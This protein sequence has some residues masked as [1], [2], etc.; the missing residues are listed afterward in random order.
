MPS[1]GGSAD[2]CFC[3]ALVTLPNDDDGDGGDIMGNGD[4][5]EEEEDGDLTPSSSPEYASATVVTVAADPILDS[6]I[7]FCCMPLLRL[8]I[9]I[10]SLS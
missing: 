4:E 5:E 1:S 7:L 10:S 9:F 2:D 6:L 8:L 3:I